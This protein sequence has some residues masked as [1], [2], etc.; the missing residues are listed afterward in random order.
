MKKVKV[1]SLL[2]LGLFALTTISQIVQS[3]EDS[4]EFVYLPVIQKP[5]NP[6]WSKV[7]PGRGLSKTVST[8]DGGMLVLS[9]RSYYPLAKL[10][11]NGDQIWE[12]KWSYYAMEPRTLTELNDGSIIIAGETPAAGNPYFKHLWVVKLGNLGDIVWQKAYS[13]NGNEANAFS[14][15]ATPNGGVAVVGHTYVNSEDYWILNLDQ[16]GSVIWQ[17]TFGSP[18]SSETATIIRTTPDNGFIIAGYSDSFSNTSDAQDI[19]IL[20]LNS[21]GII[22]WQKKVDGEGYDLIGDLAVTS[23]GDSYFVGTT[24][25][26]EDISQTDLW[27]FKLD[28]SGNLVWSKA[29]GSGKNEGSSIKATN[30]GNIYVAG[31]IINISNYNYL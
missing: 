18:T 13:H 28:S 29:Y 16:D 21:Q 31:G 2:F 9:Q 27:V 15:T 20:K 5:A 12:K 24:G 22:E 11:P 1:L 19:W 8:N 30:D 7:N 4:D 23:N 10:D 6:Y 17:R 26:W 14:L 3:Q 25:K